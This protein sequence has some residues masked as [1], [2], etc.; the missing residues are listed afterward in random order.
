MEEVLRLQLPVTE[1]NV[2]E[3]FPD[4]TDI[5]LL[6]R[7]GMS[8]IYEAISVEAQ[9]PVA[10]KVLSS[11]LDQQL[12]RERL[13]EEIEA[14]ATLDHPNIIKLFEVYET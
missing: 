3:H 1:R 6:K 4:L 7:G 13:V 11:E 2:K 5:Q 9:A 14:L 12:G 8:V 10:L